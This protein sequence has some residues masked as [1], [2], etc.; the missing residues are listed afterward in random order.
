MSE[1]S[2][3]FLGNVRHQRRKHQHHRFG[4]FSGGG[5]KSGHVIVELDQFGDRSIE[6]QGFH[7]GTHRVNGAMKQLSALRICWNINYRHRTGLLIDHV[8]P[9][10]LQKAV[11]A[12]HISGFPWPRGIEGSHGHLIEP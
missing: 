9:Q 3:K 6:P 5:L 2:P 12:D 11:H 7:L 4:D 8:A 10:P 1:L